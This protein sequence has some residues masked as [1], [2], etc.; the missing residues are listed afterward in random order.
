MYEAVDRLYSKDMPFYRKFL[1]CGR[2][3]SVWGTRDLRMAVVSNKWIGFCFGFLVSFFFLCVCGGGCLVFVL[4]CFA[5]SF[6][7]LHVFS[8]L[9]KREVLFSF[10]G[11]CNHSFIYSCNHSIYIINYKIFYKKFRE[12][13]Y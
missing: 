12:N 2:F 4:F 5:L 7:V 1:S 6:F 11:Y 10:F 13:G 9:H 3:C 8:L